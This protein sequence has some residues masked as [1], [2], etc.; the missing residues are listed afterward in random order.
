MLHPR[1]DARVRRDVAR[2][3]V[4]QV[5]APM[6]APARVAIISDIHGNL[7]ALEAV[8]ADLAAGRADAVVV[9]G[10]IAQ[11]APA[12]DRV[13]DLVRRHGWPAVLGNADAFLL[14]LHDGI[15]P[16]TVPPAL[17]DSA[18]WP[19]QHLAEEHLDF[20]R[21]LPGALRIEAADRP[22][23]MLVHATPWSIDNIVLRDAPEEVA[24]RMLETAGTPALAYGHIHS[25]YRR[26]VGGGLLFS[27]G[28]VS[29]S[30]DQDPR[31]AY[32]VVTLDR[33]IHLE[34]RRV[35]FDVASAVEAV[36]SSGAPVSEA[37]LRSMTTGGPWE[38][39]PTG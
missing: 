28:A 31:P 24:V 5:A 13:V 21:S 18:R 34:V 6:G 25:P 23:V 20:L 7:L 16:A 2:P 15:V 19:L 22:P 26:R 38:V 33:G 36:R 37:L 4:V 12:P 11:G 14:D 10:D 9:G 32:T 35:A 17:V 1:W 27:V 8:A 29:G 30:N 39:A 3:H